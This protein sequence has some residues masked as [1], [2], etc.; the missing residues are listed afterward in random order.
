MW[1]NYFHEP[2]KNCFFSEKETDFKVLILPFKAYGCNQKDDIGAEIQRQLKALN[3]LENLE[4]VSHFAHDLYITENFTQ[5]SAHVLKNRY[6]ADMVI[7][8]NYRKDECTSQSYQ[9]VCASYYMDSIRQATERYDQVSIG[10][11]RHGK[12]QG[13]V[14]SIIFW[15]AGEKNFERKNYAQALKHYLYLQDSLGEKTA[16]LKHIIGFIYKT[17]QQYEQAKNYYQQSI[18]LDSNYR[19]VYNSFGFLLNSDY[20]NDI[21]GA[22][23]MYEKAI[24]LDSNS[25]NAYNNL[26]LILS[27][28]PFLEHERAINLFN[29]AIQLDPNNHDAYHNLGL[30]IQDEPYFD[31]VNAEQLYKKVIVLNPKATSS[32]YNLSTV[33]ILQKKYSEA[34]EV[35]EKLIEIAPNTSVAYGNLGTVY[36]W[37]F[38]EF[39]NAEKNFLKALSLESENAQANFEY[40][41]FLWNH[42][43]LLSNQH[44]IKEHYLKAVRLDSA[45]RNLEFEREFEQRTGGKLLE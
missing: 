37:G 11:L 7:H 42:R 45:M 36:A 39:D 3:D 15:I 5:D 9:D 22:K 24:L 16:K 1:K 38:Q 35:L 6:C 10:E 23:K 34:K 43:P 25:S 4:I 26:G 44:K 27:K 33:L 12:M 18:A 32:Y 40:A 30:L 14:R 20:F 28:K 2:A 41:F 17:L 29:K 13:T 21:E 19:R 31:F 8:G